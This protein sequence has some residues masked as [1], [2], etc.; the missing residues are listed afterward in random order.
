MRVL[1]LGG[2]GML[3]H[4]AWQ[5]FR[6][7]FD[8]YVT[9]RGVFSE[10]ERFAIFDKKKTICGVYAEDFSVFEKIMKK[11]KPD[12]VLN[13]IGIVKQ[14]E[15]ASDPI[16][17][18]EV[19]SLFPQ[20]LVV[21]CETVN[22]RLIH[23]STDCVFSGNKSLYTEDDFPDPV[24]LYGRTKLL[25][26]VVGGDTLTIRTSMVGREIGAK[27]GLLEWFLSQNGKSVK[28]YR[29]AIFSGFTTTAL[30]AILKDIIIKHADFRGLYHISSDPISKYNLL[31]LIKEQ[32]D[33]KT[34][35]IP[36]EEIRYN[37]T[38]DS[39]KF[40]KEATYYPPSWED[41]VKEMAKEIKTR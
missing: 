39:S 40:R 23:L 15:E 4:A 12:V 25:G 24:D 36:D 16:R 38:L 18:I 28:G 1:I 19:N 27:H 11:V 26:E 14:V 7:D 37:R 3:G 20:R 34:I 5:S 35:I 30:C 21:L 6:N 17:S 9:I 33:L 32:M 10:V 29:N 41:M 8:V 13:C 22:C 2:N 31:L